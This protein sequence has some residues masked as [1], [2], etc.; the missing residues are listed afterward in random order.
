LRLDEEKKRY[1]LD[2]SE[3]PLRK[4]ENTSESKENSDT[5]SKIK[6]LNVNVSAYYPSAMKQKLNDS[7]ASGNETNDQNSHSNQSYLLYN[8][9]FGNFLN[10]DNI[11][12]G[13]LL[14]LSPSQYYN[15]YPMVSM[16]QDRIL[17]LNKCLEYS[18]NN[19]NNFMNNYILNYQ[20]GP[21]EKSLNEY[22]DFS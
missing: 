6:K 19:T 10:Y 22:E 8:N 17:K 3:T 4:K 16:L 2:L 18:N 14:N 7:F 9:Q 12:Q 20:K 13:Y 11:N 5:K 21:N 1:I 15:Y